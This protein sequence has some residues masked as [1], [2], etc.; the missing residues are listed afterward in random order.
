[1]KDKELANV[2]ALSAF[3]Q[4]EDEI[5]REQICEYRR[6]HCTMLESSMSR[7]SNKGLYS[8]VPF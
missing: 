1:M 2:K 5:N 4:R 7:M 3:T 6:L 8:A